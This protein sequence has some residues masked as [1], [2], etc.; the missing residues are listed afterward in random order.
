MPARIVVVHDD[1]EFSEQLAGALRSGGHDVA[2]YVDPLAAW[3]ALEA[4]KLVEVLVTR[5]EYSPGRSNGFALARMARLKRPQIK[6]LFTALPEH[7][8]NAADLGE[9]LPMPVS[10]EDTIEAIT[11]LLDGQNKI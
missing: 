3:D 1:L 10:V 7:A 4:A 9:F 11:G 2:T 5:V 6:V 8:E